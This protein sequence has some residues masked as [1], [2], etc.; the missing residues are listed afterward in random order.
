MPGLNGSTTA[1]K[2]AFNAGYEAGGEDAGGRMMGIA[3]GE[4]PAGC[5]LS[6]PAE[7]W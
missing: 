1:M 6:T 7:R 2:M 4:K 5:P 3:T